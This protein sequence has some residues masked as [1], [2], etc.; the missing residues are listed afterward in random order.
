MHA[1]F[2]GSDSWQKVISMLLAVA[3]DENP[4]ASQG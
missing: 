2:A 4:F 1:L 3:P